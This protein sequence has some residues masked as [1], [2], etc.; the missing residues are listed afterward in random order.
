MAMKLYNG[1]WYTDQL[2]AGSKASG[3]TISATDPTTWY[4][5]SDVLTSGVSAPAGTTAYDITKNPDT[6]NQA[7]AS[8]ISQATSREANLFPSNP[9][10]NYAT[11]TPYTQNL[12]TGNGTSGGAFDLGDM[13][14]N[15]GENI[16]ALQKPF[17]PSDTDYLGVAFGAKRQELNAAT[18]AERTAKMAALNRALAAQG[19]AGPAAESAR[20]EAE[21]NIGTT[22][23]SAENA[24]TTSEGEARANQEISANQLA[25]GIF[26]TGLQAESALDQIKQNYLSSAQTSTDSEHRLAGYNSGYSGGSRPGDDDPIGQMGYDIGHTQKITDVY[27]F[28]KAGITPSGSSSTST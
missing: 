8:A 4:L 16:A 5:E 18:S 19:I 24:L 27:W 1:Q 13:A 17:Q 11:N 7:S 28:D 3:H 15:Y 14:S 6:Q 22:R 26:Q 20:R 25:A 10:I 12:F 23:Q 21:G 9:A 2:P